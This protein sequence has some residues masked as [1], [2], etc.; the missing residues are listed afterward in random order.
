MFGFSRQ[1]VVKEAEPAEDKAF[2]NRRK[3]S[4]ERVACRCEFTLPSTDPFIHC[5]VQT[6]GLMILN[7][8]GCCVYPEE[9]LSLEDTKKTFPEA[10]LLT[11]KKI[12]LTGE[13]DQEFVLENLSIRR[14]RLVT[15]EH[16]D[17]IILRFV[18]LT[19]EQ[20]DLLVSLSNRYA[21]KDQTKPAA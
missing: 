18:N 17:G 11:L 14:V 15:D 6:K 12:V 20:L 4:G 1:P 3:V 21:M 9:V 19:E 7:V 8:R 16:G 10:R 2:R 13:D 5:K